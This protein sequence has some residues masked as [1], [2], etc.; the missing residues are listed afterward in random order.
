MSN[1]ETAID[2]IKTMPR[3]TKDPIKQI[4]TNTQEENIENNVNI[5]HGVEK[6]ITGKKEE[7]SGT[8][9]PVI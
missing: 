4:T 2:E 1:E 6:K 5:E 8:F 9:V 3:V 7:K